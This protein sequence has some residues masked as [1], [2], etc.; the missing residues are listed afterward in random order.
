MKGERIARVPEG[1][2]KWY[3]A[4]KGFGFITRTDTNE[5]VFVH[6]SGIQKDGFKSLDQGQKV[7]FD[8]ISSDRGAKAENVKPA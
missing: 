8:I 2:V 3:D 6:W 5:D 4:K 7:T 1:T